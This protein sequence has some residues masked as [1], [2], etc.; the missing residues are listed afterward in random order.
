LHNEKIILGFPLISADIDVFSRFLIRLA[1][2]PFPLKKREAARL[3][4]TTIA[5]LVAEADAANYLS[6]RQRFQLADLLRDLRKAARRS[7][8]RLGETSTAWHRV[9]SRLETY[10]DLG[11]LQKF[12]EEKYEYVYNAS[13][14]LGKIANTLQ[15]TEDPQEWFDRHFVG[16]VSGVNAS[17]DLVNTAELIS[18]LPPI[19][20]A[21]RSP[22]ST[23]PIDTVALGVAKLPADAGAPVLGAARRSVEDL[24]KGRPDV[25]RLARGTS[26]ERAEFITIISR[27]V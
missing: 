22:S 6:A 5:D 19:L 21:I 15:S 24:A 2:S 27:A 17:E 14:G 16:A 10:V 23:L 1:Q 7:E 3:F 9:S 20:Q 8:D 18:I 4:S 25:A 11:F 12:G 13:P 26:G